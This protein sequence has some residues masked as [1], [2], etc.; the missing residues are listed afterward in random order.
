MLGQPW[1]DRAHHS[2]GDVGHA[3]AVG[4]AQRLEHQDGEPADG[5]VESGL[6]TAADASRS[7]CTHAGQNVTM[8]L[9]NTFRL[10]SRASA[11]SKSF[12]GTSVSITGV[13]P[14]SILPRLSC[15]L[16][17]VQPND[18]KIRYCCR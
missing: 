9:P 2:P 10:S 5:G 1:P 11:L 14:A 16:R 7:G 6:E 17:N 3:L 15:T 4:P 13:N 8:I 18:P 12:S